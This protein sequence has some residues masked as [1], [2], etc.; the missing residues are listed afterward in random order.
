MKKKTDVSV[1]ISPLTM[2]IFA[3]FITKTLTD[4]LPLQLNGGG[5]LYPENLHPFPLFA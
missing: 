5:L 1:N 2:L 4:L 3:S